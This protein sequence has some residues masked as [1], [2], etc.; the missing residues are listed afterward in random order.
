MH[1]WF[2]FSSL[3]RFLMVL[4]LIGVTAPAA[5][6]VK[7]FKDAFQ[8]KYIK[9][10]STAPN[11]VALAQAFDQAGCAVCHA[12][13]NN[14]KIRN[15]Y[16]KQVAKLITKRDGRNKPR[17]AAA[18]DTVAKLK[19]NPSDSN[20][21]TYAERIASGKL[22]AAEL[23]A[24]PAGDPGQVGPPRDNRR[25]GRPGRIRP[26]GRPGEPDD[27]RGGP[28]PGPDGSPSGPPPGPDAP[29]GEP[30]APRPDQPPGLPPR[31]PR[32]ALP[33]MEKNDPEI[34]Q[35]LQQ[36]KD[37]G[38]RT[39][40]AAAALRAAPEDQR[41]RLKD[42][43]KKL[44][45]EQFKAYQQRRRLELN[46]LEAELKRLREAADGRDKNSEQI[47]EKRVSDL[48]GEEPKTGS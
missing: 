39:Q 12:G 28:P 10:D 16:G 38:R 34:D 9:P 23:D 15:D 31:G 44:V 33:P 6:A 19:T 27:R 36:E 14:K 17:I 2:A 45:T 7:E 35:L 4:G 25:P 11:D 48:M 43:L 5:M 20:S 26:E 21:P 47:I 40:E 30:G 41:G 24:A 22:P 32:P 42:D 3:A 18:L 8:A 1:K 13:G 46:R 37:L 29:P